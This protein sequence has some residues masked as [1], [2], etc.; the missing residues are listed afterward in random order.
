[1]S[2]PLQLSKRE[3]QIM[4]SIYRRGE[5]SAVEVL[6]D[7]PDPPSRTSVRTLLRILETKGHLSHR[8]QGKE[9]V[10]KPIKSRERVA[11]PALRRVL[12][13]FFGGSI[14]RAMAAHLADPK[15]SLS[16]E[17]L[18]RL[19]KLIEQAKRKED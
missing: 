1:M 15:I 10:Y 17:E 16:D 13:T 19:T 5:A 11:K 14:A 9:F 4:E 18:E 6:A 3:R 2:D 7:L 12:E 8:V